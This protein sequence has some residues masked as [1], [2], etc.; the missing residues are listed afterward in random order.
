MSHK[1]L[2]FKPIRS[3]M[4]RS[5]LLREYCLAVIF[6]FLSSQGPKL[7]CFIK[8][9]DGLSEVVTEYYIKCKENARIDAVLMVKDIIVIYRNKETILI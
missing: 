8:V 3:S 4:I 6:Q 2:D 1:V 7:Q 5:Y 9:K